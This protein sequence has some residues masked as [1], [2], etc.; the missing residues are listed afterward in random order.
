MAYPLSI[1][2]TSTLQLLVLGYTQ[3]WSNPNI[4]S[5][6]PKQFQKRIKH[7]LDGIKDTDYTWLNQ[8][9]HEVAEALANNITGHSTNN[10]HVNARSFVNLIQPQEDWEMALSQLERLAFKSN[11][12]PDIAKE[13]SIDTQQRLVWELDLTRWNSPIQPKIQKLG[14][15]GWSKG[16]EISKEKLLEFDTPIN[17]SDKEHLILRKLQKSQAKW[18]SGDTDLE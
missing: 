6:D 14:R 7:A 2:G 5:F 12:E 15:N 1:T 8:E 10:S 13:N 16:K 11:Q 17:I 3:C 9:L 4:V 18:E